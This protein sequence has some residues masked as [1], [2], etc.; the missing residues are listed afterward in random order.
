MTLRPFTLQ[1]H[2]AVNSLLR[3]MWWPARSEAGWRWLETNPTHDA[4][5]PFGWVA[6]DK[7]GQVAAFTGNFIQRYWRAGRPMRAATGHSI[8]VTKGARGASR[9]LI[10]ACMGQRDLAMAFALNAN[11]VSQPLYDRHGLKPFPNETHALKL[12]WPTAPE[13]LAAGWL[14]R[15]VAMPFP[16]LVRALGEQMMNR[17]VG[18]VDYGRLPEGVTPLTDLGDASAYA[19][20]WDTLKQEDR[21]LADRS[22][23]TVRWRLADPDLTQAPILLA[24]WGEG[25]ITGVCWAAVSK[26][27]PLAPPVLEIIDLEALSGATRAIP[28]L[29]TAVRGMARA[30]G[31]AKVR[32]QVVSPL[33]LERLG[34]HRDNARTEG[35]W[36]HAHVA[37]FDEGLDQAWS[38]TPFDSDYSF[39][40][41]P[42]PIPAPRLPQRTVDGIAAE[43]R[44]WS[45][46]AALATV[47]TA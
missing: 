37:F 10:K 22:P 38:P 6:E 17:R 46:P 40:L 45:R 5:D 8:V 19:A 27:D 43:R 16:K 20:F 23:A 42:A 33:Q 24:A 34:A 25:R 29:M 7:N 15:R 1:D 13:A 41:R 39:C 4:D 9:T 11:A 47:R 32:L 12:S 26:L 44:R 28:A 3:Q 30:C 2:Q 14:L 21:L 36:G 18:R 31:A 35:G